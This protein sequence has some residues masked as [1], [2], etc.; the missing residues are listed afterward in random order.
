[1]KQRIGV[2]LTGCGAY[3]GSEIQEAVLALLEIQRAGHQPVPIALDAPQLHVVDH[4]SAGEKEEAE[5]RNQMEE[6]ARITRGRIFKVS[7]VSSHHFAALIIPGGQGAAKN[8]MTSF[9]E[10]KPPELHPTLKVLLSEMAQGKRPLGAISLG[11]FALTQV[12]GE[13]FSQKGCFDVAGD[14]VLLDEERKFALTPG[15]TTAEN[16]LQVEKGI[17]ALVEALI[18]WVDP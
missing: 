2:L 18:H 9:G 13:A 3:D 5:P 11:E 10:S 7:E 12:D 4:M 15:F 14:E 17:H 6:S 8:I 1:M 16:I